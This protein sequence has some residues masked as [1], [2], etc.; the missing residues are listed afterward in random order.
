M[1][2]DFRRHTVVVLA[3]QLFSARQMSSVVQVKE[4][5]RRIPVVS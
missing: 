5:S 1:T 2:G 4:I 3:Q